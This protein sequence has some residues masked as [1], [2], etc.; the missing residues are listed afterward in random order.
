MNIGSKLSKEVIR[1]N[2]RTLSELKLTDMQINKIA[3]IVTRE[4]SLDANDKVTPECQQEIQKIE[5]IKED[6]V[7]IIGSSVYHML[8]SLISM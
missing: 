3:E 7:K 5:G 4:G 1:T 8:V 6:R 2:L